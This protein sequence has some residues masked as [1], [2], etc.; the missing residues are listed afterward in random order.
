MVGMPPSEPPAGHDDKCP[1][2]G[3]LDRICLL[4]REA[5]NGLRP[6]VA[7]TLEIERLADAALV[8]PELREL[9]RDPAPEARP[10]FSVGAPWCEPP[11]RYHDTPLTLPE[12]AP[13]V[14]ELA[15][16]EFPAPVAVAVPEDPK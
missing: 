2:R 13:E 7:A 3:A 16:E 1:F 5:N 4:A 8:L 6:Y 9:V 12:L 10:R 14:P 11:R 15:P